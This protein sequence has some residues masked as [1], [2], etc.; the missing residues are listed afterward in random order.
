MKKVTITSNNISA[1]QWSNLLLE[2]NLMR[3]AW[4]PYATLNLE[5]RGL[6][7]V[8]KWGTSTNFKSND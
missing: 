8:I 7:N 4:K 3:K 2:L 1:K 6:K 5:A